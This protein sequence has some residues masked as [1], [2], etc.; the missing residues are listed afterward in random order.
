MAFGWTAFL[1][2]EG[3]DELAEKADGCAHNEGLGKTPEQAPGQ[4]VSLSS[5]G[6]AACL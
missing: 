1:R 3:W 2:S 6:I 4:K 5:P